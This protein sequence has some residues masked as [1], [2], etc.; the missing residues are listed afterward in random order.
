M[1]SNFEVFWASIEYLYAK[2]HADYKNLKGGFVYVFKYT[3]NVEAFLSEIEK[4]FQNNFLKIKKIEFIKKYDSEVHWESVNEIKH[5]NN[6]VR[7][8]ISSKKLLFDD[9]YAYRR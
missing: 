7:S 4:E 3:V 9:F 8:A 1:S 6:L 2:D 5:Y